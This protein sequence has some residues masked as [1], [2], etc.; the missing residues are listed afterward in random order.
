MAMRSA[1]RVSVNEAPR[2]I[3]LV[4]EDEPVLLASI[5]RGLSKLAGIDVLEAASV[6]EAR[7]VL[8]EHTPAMVLSDLDLPDGSGIDVAVELEQRAMHVPLVFVSAYVGQFKNLLPV[9]AEVLEKPVSMDRLRVLV[10][11][12]L[13]SDVEGSPFGVADYVQLAGMSRRSVVLEVALPD[14][15]GRVVIRSGHL[16]AAFDAQGSGIAAF[17]RLAF[18]PDV[19]VVCRQLTSDDAVVVNVDGSCESIL[20][21]VARELDERASGA[22]NASVANAAPSPAES[23][24][25]DPWAEMTTEVD[26]EHVSTAAPSEVR[27]ASEPARVRGIVTE[28]R[29]LD[30]DLRASFEKCVERGL[31]AIVRKDFR[32]AYAAFREAERLAPHDRAVRANVLRLEELRAERAAS[33][34]VT[35]R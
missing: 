34:S 13:K 28:P 15:W 25:A 19:D 6:A 10:E 35:R 24:A 27:L 30:D 18:Q 31:A 32:A 11:E 3:V 26:L 9:R 1:E 29:A 33:A 22:A 5:G 16:I 23:D 12:R 17:R 14:G 4:V 8:A 21:D 20:L 7:A 2:R